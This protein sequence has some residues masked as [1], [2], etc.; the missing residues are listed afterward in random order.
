MSEVEC[1][2]YAIMHSCPCVSHYSIG[3]HGL[4]VSRHCYCVHTYIIHHSLIMLSWTTDTTVGM[5]VAVVC[6]LC[7]VTQCLVLAISR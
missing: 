3:C 1:I 2:V 5:Y 6:A 4:Q 7:A